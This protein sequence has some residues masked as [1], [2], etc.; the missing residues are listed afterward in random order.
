MTRGSGPSKLP[1]GRAQGPRRWGQPLPL[2][3]EPS[4]QRL[5]SSQSASFLLALFPRKVFRA[6]TASKSHSVES[7]PP[8]E[9]LQS[10]TESK[11]P[12]RLTIQR[13]AYCLQERRR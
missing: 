9:R 10:T 7:S 13:T 4:P 6:A 2:E 8:R 5:S 3:T 11:A 12:G 1:A